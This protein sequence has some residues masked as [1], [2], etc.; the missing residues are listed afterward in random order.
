MSVKSL[1]DVIPFGKYKGQTVDI[2]LEDL[3]Y[4][5]WCGKQD[6]IKKYPKIYSAIKEFSNLTDKNKVVKCHTCSDECNPEKIINCESCGLP[7]HRLCIMIPKNC[8]ICNKILCNVCMFYNICKECIG[9]KCS[10]YCNKC[11]SY[12]ECKNKNLNDM[13]TENIHK[14]KD[15]H[16]KFL[17]FINKRGPYAVWTGS[18]DFVSNTNYNFENATFINSKRVAEYYCHTF[19]RIF[20]LSESLDWNSQIVLPQYPINFNN[21]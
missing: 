16:N 2:F 1:L 3:A 12:A 19:E 13:F 11:I 8:N 6:W 7:S 15:G 14:N 5:E 4:M 10:V 20:I 21:K 9:F 18:M 17:V